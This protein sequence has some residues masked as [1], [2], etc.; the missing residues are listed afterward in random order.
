M[1]NE[2]INLKRMNDLLDDYVTDYK[3]YTIEEKKEELDSYIQLRERAIR[4]S[5]DVSLAEI[6]EEIEKLK[7][8]LKDDF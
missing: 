2:S 6:D 8:C 7:A 5:D 1:A 3:N 4:E